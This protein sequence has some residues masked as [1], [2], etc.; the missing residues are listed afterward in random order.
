[1]KARWV[2]TAL[3]AVLAVV[4][5]AS[6]AFVLGAIVTIITVTRVVMMV[7]WQRRR[8]QTPRARRQ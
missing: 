3:T 8:A 2:M 6:G 7:L 4:L 1:M 5:F